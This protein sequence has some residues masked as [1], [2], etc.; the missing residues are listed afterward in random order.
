MMISLESNLP[1]YSSC[2][3]GST[4]KTGLEGSAVHS[5]NFSDKL[6]SS[7]LLVVYSFIPKG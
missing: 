3:N 6:C 4:S 7:H 5:Y 2:V 1:A